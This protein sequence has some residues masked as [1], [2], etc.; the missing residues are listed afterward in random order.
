MTAQATKT[1]REKEQPR[2][3]SWAQATRAKLAQ[4]KADRKAET[5]TRTAAKK[6]P[7]E[8]ACGCGQL[9][10]GVFA[11]GHDATMNAAFL[12]VAR[13]DADLTGADER[14]TAM[15][16]A[17]VMER[18]DNEAGHHVALAKLAA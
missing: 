15:F 12:A 3:I 6:E 9:T 5:K 16:R 10:K 2:G 7:R 17:W 1:P 11:P 13:G 14:T 18:A 4:E 8:C